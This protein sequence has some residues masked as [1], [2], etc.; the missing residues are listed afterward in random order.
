MQA[1]VGRVMQTYA[2]MID[3][4]PEEEEVTRQKL[5][6]HLAG[7]DADEKTLTVEGFAICADQ[8]RVSR[9]KNGE[10]SNM[11][12]SLTKRD[13]PDRSK[14]NNDHDRAQGRHVVGPGGG[15][16]QPNRLLTCTQKCTQI[17]FW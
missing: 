1:A 3:L 14:I 16:G 2:M 11:T 13:Q 4:T 7:M 5:E 8:G 6:R 10:G 17:R 12:D 15:I 9:A